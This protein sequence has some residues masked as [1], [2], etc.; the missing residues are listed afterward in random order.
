MPD[1]VSTA[2]N[3]AEKALERILLRLLQ[4][5]KVRDAVLFAVRHPEAHG[6][7]RLLPKEEREAERAKRRFRK[8]L[9]KPGMRGR[10]MG[11]ANG[12]AV[13]S[14]NAPGGQP[15]DAS[16][17]SRRAGKSHAPSAHPKFRSRR[18]PRS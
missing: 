15:P 11:T 2:D 18:E 9:P 13:R 7:L 3:A 10:D 8:T 14:S 12:A 4:R 6:R 17:D 16:P 5:P 1:N